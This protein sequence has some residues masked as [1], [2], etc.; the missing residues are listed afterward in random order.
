MSLLGN[1]NQKGK[2]GNKNAKNA[3][4]SKF[5]A[6]GSKLSKPGGLSKKPV[7]T[8]GTRGS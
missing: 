7:K 6:K 3:G 4:G 8:G 2:S 5:I 1:S